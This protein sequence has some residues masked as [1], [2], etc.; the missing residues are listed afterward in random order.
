MEGEGRRERGGEGDGEKGGDTQ[1][2]HILI[3]SLVYINVH[4][5]LDRSELKLGKIPP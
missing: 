2:T 1:H 3:G 4:T 5:L